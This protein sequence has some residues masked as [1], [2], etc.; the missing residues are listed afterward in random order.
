MLCTG[1]FEAGGHP[2]RAGPGRAVAAV[3]GAPRACPC[4]PRFGEACDGN[5]SSPGLATE[6]AEKPPLEPVLAAVPADPP[7]TLAACPT[8][9]GGPT[10]SALPGIA[11]G[12]PRRDPDPAGLTD[13]SLQ[14]LSVA[15]LKYGK[16]FL[17]PNRR[18]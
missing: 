17:V 10:P 14:Y 1:P 13:A 12:S 6:G 18:R 15:Y 9:G 4:R 3:V 2:R 7:V 11:S 5:C 16:V 8:P